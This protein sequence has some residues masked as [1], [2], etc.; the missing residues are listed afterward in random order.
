M[1]SQAAREA[2]LRELPRDRSAILPGVIASVAIHALAL[3]VQA[4]LP[5]LF[6][7]SEAAVSPPSRIEAV[8]RYPAAIQP[9]PELRTAEPPPPRRKLLA[10]PVATPEPA[11]QVIAEPEPEPDRDVD[12]LP[13]PLAP[14]RAPDPAA[15][16]SAP[17]SQPAIEA[18]RFDAAYLD[19]PRPAYPLMARRRGQEGE[20]LLEVAVGAD[21]RALRAEV[22][23]SSGFSLLDGA[24]QRAVSGWRFV[25]ARRGMVTIE[26]TVRVPIRFRLDD[27]GS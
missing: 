22:L 21:G 11:A 14:D 1:L 27:P 9:P 16:T 3:G 20:V 26:A 2:A 24:A 23:R 5:G 25:P 12:V 17:V 4:E 6:A 19:N 7:A 10:R 18:P 8:L 15:A 13:A